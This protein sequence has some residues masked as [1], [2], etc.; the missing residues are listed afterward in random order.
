MT[1]TEDL[2]LALLGV[3]L[4]V[5]VYTKKK[6]SGANPSAGSLIGSIKKLTK[7]AGKQLTKKLQ[8]DSEADLLTAV[9]KT[10]AR[11]AATIVDPETKTPPD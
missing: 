10:K 9:T 6:L 3:V 1:L 8:A 7:V 4:A 11:I 2:L 5:L